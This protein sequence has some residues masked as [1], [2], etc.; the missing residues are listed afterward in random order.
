M[1]NSIPEPVALKV[2]D[3]APDFT[4]PTHNEGELNLA[5]Y[6]GRKNVILAFYP[7]DWTP[8]CS[9]Q[10]P[11]Y[12]K[13]QDQ[14][15]RLNSQLLGISVDSIPCTIAC[16]PSQSPLLSRSRARLNS[17]MASIGCL[18]RVRSLRG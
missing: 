1:T 12:V 7:A 16:A 5:W 17:S 14:F 13:L 15:D 2:G 4:L 8:V 3:E 9:S 10:I 6:R 11:A 18:L